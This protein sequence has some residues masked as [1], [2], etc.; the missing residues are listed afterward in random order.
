[1]HT[2][3]ILLVAL[4][5]LFGTLLIPTLPACSAQQPAIDVAGDGAEMV[6]ALRAHLE[7][8]DAW[9]EQAQTDLEALPALTES[10]AAFRE[11]YDAERYSEAIGHL[12]DA[13]KV[14]QDAGHEVPE[15]VPR[16]LIAAQALASVLGK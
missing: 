4:T 8:L 14:V 3:K 1:M 13:V 9:L 5:L 7:Q 11:A 2:D 16:R 12:T 10:L 6:T 15:D